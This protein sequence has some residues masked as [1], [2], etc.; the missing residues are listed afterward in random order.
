MRVKAAVAR[1]HGAPLAIAD[2]DLDEPR[3]GEILVRV[4]ACGVA[5]CDR[6]AI[7][8]TLAMPLP[9]VPGCEG[10]GI[11]E[12]VGEGVSVPAAGDAVLI[13]GAPV[14]GGRALAGVRPDGTAP[15][16][17]ETAAGAGAVNGF[18][19]G[20][21]AFASHMLCPAELAV[22]VADGAP[23]ELLA[24]LGREVLLGAGLVLR[25][26]AGAAG[27][28]IV[29][30]GA[31][32]VGLGAC[33][34]APAA[35]FGMIVVADPRESRREL[36]LKVGATI[37][38]PADEGLGAVVKSLDA[39]GA[40]YALETS[41]APAARAGCE[42]SLAAGGKCVVVTPE[43]L[44]R[45]DVGSILPRLVAL[46]AGERFPLEELVAYFPFEHVDDALAAHAA[47]EVV[48]PILR[49]SLGAFGALDRALQEGAA[50]DEPSGEPD[51]AP[52]DAPVE[53]EREAPKVTA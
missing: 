8:G 29:I 35:G 6:E 17:E 4:I 22:P 31:D 42:A 41:G 1:A 53:G 43:S 18:F 11:V 25:D 46:H 40:R 28:T 49:F 10:A 2:L 36:A 34:A 21:S 24:G 7:D 32:A 15:F 19:F 33:M 26:G 20:Q 39:D 30:T 14:P 3:A 45:V 37:A 27:A 23:L 12:R 47:D 5:L 38:V 44:G 50:T 52:A 51:T 48:K 16:N 9:F 13:V